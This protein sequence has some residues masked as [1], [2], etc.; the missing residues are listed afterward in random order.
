MA[1]GKQIAAELLP[2]PGSRTSIVPGDMG[3]RLMGHYGKGQTAAASGLVGSA[4]PAA[5]R[6][7]PIRDSIGRVS[8][9]PRTDSM[10]GTRR[11]PK[12]TGI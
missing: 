11:Y 7:S 4:M 10:G 12:Q 1:A 6:I 9:H 5:S 2:M 3:S 8:P